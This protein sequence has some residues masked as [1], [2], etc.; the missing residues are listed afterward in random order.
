MDRTSEA[1][2]PSQFASDVNE[3]YGCACWD[4]MRNHATNFV[5]LYVALT[6]VYWIRSSMTSFNEQDLDETEKDTLQ[7][8]LSL[9]VKS[10][11]CRIDRG[12]S[13]MELRGTEYIVVLECGIG[14]RSVRRVDQDG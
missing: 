2:F 10:Q 11:L 6:S 1:R 12:G 5:Q 14:K 9:G 13:A 4:E 7:D 8:M 3:G